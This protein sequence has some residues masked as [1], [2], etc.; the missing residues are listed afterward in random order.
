MSHLFI[1]RANIV[2]EGFLINKVLSKIFAFMERNALGVSEFFRIPSER[3]IEL[4][5]YVDV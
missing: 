5:A 1:G 3:V 2:P 4:G